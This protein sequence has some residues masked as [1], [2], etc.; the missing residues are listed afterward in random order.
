MICGENQGLPSSP[1]SQCST[2]EDEEAQNALERSQRELLVNGKDVGEG[3]FDLQRHYDNT[4]M[5]KQLIEL[6][7]SEQDAEIALREIHWQG[8]QVAATWHF[9]RQDGSS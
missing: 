6:G 5:L 9:Q 4:L 3:F 8:A 2:L 7:L 1:L